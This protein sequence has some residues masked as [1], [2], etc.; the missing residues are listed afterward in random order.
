MEWFMG[1]DG[2][3]WDGMGEWKGFGWVNVIDGWKGMDGRG[4]KDLWEGMG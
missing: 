3:E 4:W 2:M 1:G